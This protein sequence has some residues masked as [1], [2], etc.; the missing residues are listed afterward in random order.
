MYIYIE[1]VSTMVKKSIYHWNYIKQ[2]NEI[3]QNVV[4]TFLYRVLPNI[5]Y[6]NTVHSG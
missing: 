5:S 4:C 2:L 6:R 3:V 1:F